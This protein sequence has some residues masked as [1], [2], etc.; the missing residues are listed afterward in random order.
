MKTKKIKL[1]DVAIDFLSNAIEEKKMSLNDAIIEWN[2][3]QEVEKFLKV[4]DIV[5]IYCEDISDYR[6]KKGFIGA[7]L[8]KCGTGFDLD[9]SGKFSVYWFEYNGNN[10]QADFLGYEL[11]PTGKS[12]TREFLIDYIKNIDVSDTMHKELE[13]A[14]QE[15]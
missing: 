9:Q 4:G 8:R 10:F 1:P 3:K 12:I 7:V 2:R 6:G 11:E 14:I 13:K 5:K 15:I